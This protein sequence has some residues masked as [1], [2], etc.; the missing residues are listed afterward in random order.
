LAGGWVLVATFSGCGQSTSTFGDAAAIQAMQQAPDPSAVVAA[1]ANG[2]AI[3]HNDSKLDEAYVK[4]MV[5]LGLPEMAYH[6]A[7]TLTTM[8]S[9]NGLAWGVVAYVDARR[10]QMAEAISAINLAGQFAPDNKFVAH[11]AGELAAWYD[12]KADKTKLP[13]NVKGGLA[14][15]RAL[16]GKQ[17][18]FVE[19]YDTAT[20]AYQAQAQSAQLSAEAA[21]RQTAQASEVPESPRLP[22]APVAAPVTQPVIQ[23]DQIAPLGY[24]APAPAPAYYPADYGSYYDWSPDYYANWGPDWIA[25]APWCWWQPCGFWGGSS[26]FPFGSACL[27]GDFDD[28]HHFH[29]GGDFGYGDH[30]GHGAG[31]GP[32]GSLG[33]SNGSAFWHHDAPGGNSFFGTPARPSSS[34]AS[35]AHQGSP[36]QSAM[37][38]AGTASHW[39]T[40]AGQGSLASAARQGLRSTQASAAEGRWNAPAFSTATVSQ[41]G[42]ATSRGSWNLAPSTAARPGIVAGPSVATVPAAR[43]WSGS[44]RVYQ[45]APVPR[46]T[47]SVPTYRAPV[48]ST[49]HWTIPSGGGYGGYR[50]APQYGGGNRGGTAM[51]A[52]PRYYG[53][54]SVSRGFHGG[55]FSGGSAGGFGGGFHS[56]GFSGGFHSGGFNGGSSGGFHGGGHR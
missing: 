17:T 32:S 13:D 40:G 11:S 2:N 49:P 18:A 47:W 31:F 6:Q 38:R 24:A 51:N 48:Y 43:S 44:S 8:Q 54:S 25:P 16:L 5:E 55:G 26:F 7:H 9:S 28:F 3:N 19:A 23:G 10:G 56:G 45:A 37:T 30:F 14:R 46:S 33:R 22:A 50:Q 29:H 21:T 15:V 42:R 53:G 12:A 34:A 1:Y 20:K 39:W 52:A 36:S 41:G 4:R 35:W 27:F